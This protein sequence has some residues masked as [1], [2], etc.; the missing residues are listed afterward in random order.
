MPFLKPAFVARVIAALEDYDLA[1]PRDGQFHHPLAAVYRTRL[2][3][4]I[5]DL[6]A[7]GRLRPYFLLE[8]VRAREI[9]LADLRSVDPELSSLRNINTPEEYAAALRAA[10]IVP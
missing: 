7:A 5:R 2:L 1:M 3:P 10:G 4:K 8:Q 6:I 9:D